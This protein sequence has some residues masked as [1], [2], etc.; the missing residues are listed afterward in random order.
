MILHDRGLPPEAVVS[1]EW[2]MKDSFLFMAIG[3]IW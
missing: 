1:G 3:L 2:I